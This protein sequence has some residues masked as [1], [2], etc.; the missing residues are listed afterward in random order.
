MIY[1][2]KTKKIKSILHDKS[3]KI[4]KFFKYNFIPYIKL[5]HV[6]VLCVIVI[7][8]IVSEIISLIYVSSNTYL[9][10]IFANI[11]SGLLTGIVINLIL[12]I[13]TISLY[14]TECLMKWL[15]L[16]HDNIL[17]YF[18]IYA[19]L[20]KESKNLPYD[21]NVF[22]NY[23]WK[24]FEDKAYITICIAGNINDSIAE[25][26][27]NKAVPFNSYKYIKRVL[28]YDAKQHYELNLDYRN[29]ISNLCE[30]DMTPE[31][32]E[33]EFKAINNQLR[34]LNSGILNIISKLNEK[35]KVI[36]TTII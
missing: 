34:E 32:L 6:W 4:F 9:S 25:G 3:H 11:F 15:N 21:N 23:H 10:S 20:I 30:E 26:I 14:R 27:F 22:Q 1:I 28:K 2:N 33:N 5:P 18:V 8:A 17:K 7:L 24:S 35:M 13:K 19:E 31:V 29:R 16:L 36:N 12:T